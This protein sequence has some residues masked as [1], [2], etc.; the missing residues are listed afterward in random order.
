[1]KKMTTTPIESIN[2]VVNA[3]RDMPETKHI[4]NNILMMS[5]TAGECNKQLWPSMEYKEE[6]K[7]RY[8]SIRH[9]AAET[10]RMIDDVIA[11]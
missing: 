4:L 10:L 8:K 2:G 1:M 3:Q 9:R 7:E 5:V 6:I 11:S